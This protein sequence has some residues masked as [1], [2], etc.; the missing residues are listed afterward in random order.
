MRRH[1]VVD[2]P[3]ITQMTADYHRLNF[4]PV[5]D[6]PCSVYSIMQ[7]D[8]LKQ[9][10]AQICEICGQAPA[11]RHRVVDDPQITQ[12]TADYHRLNFRP[13]ID[14]PRSAYSIMQHDSPKRKSV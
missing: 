4:R 14:E 5:I 8:N 11:R 3:Q 10:S 12:M 13:V 7:H 6:E 2:D 9:K 1:R